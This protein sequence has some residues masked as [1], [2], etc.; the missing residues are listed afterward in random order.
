VPLCTDAFT[1]KKVATPLQGRGIESRYNA[2]HVATQPKGPP[3]GGGGSGDASF[4]NGVINTIGLTRLDLR[5]YHTSFRFYYR[6]RVASRRQNLG[7]LSWVP[8]SSL[9]SLNETDSE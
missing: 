8:S 3:A 1:D 9:G 7:I 6:I 5:E 4:E 2:T